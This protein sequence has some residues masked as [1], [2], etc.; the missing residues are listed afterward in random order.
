[1]YD[2]ECILGIQYISSQELPKLYIR[3]ED[4]I[5]SDKVDDWETAVVILKDDNDKFVTKTGNLNIEAIISYGQ[6]EQAEDTM[7]T[8]AVPFRYSTYQLQK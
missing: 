8:M 6:D 7:E 4:D 3:S 2:A 5:I 1:M